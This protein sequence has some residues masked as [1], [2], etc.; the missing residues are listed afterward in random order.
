MCFFSVF[1]LSM[2]RKPTV[3]KCY[4]RP[5]IFGYTFNLIT[6]I[7]LIKSINLLKIF[8]AKIRL[9]NSEIRM[10]RYVDAIIVLICIIAE[11]MVNMI[12]IFKIPPTVVQQ[13]NIVT[14]ERV[15]FCSNNQHIILHIIATFLTF[16]VFF[17]SIVSYTKLT[18]RV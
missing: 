11:T 4:I 16:F 13:I 15:I 18:E 17:N 3:L 7:V 2:I 8:K 14:K 1:P 5:L 6:A 12:C 10:S 9:S